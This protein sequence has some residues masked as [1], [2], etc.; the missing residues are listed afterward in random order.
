MPRRPRCRYISGFPD[1]W[2]FS[3]DDTEKNNGVITLTLDEYEVIRLIDKEGYN[4]EQ[5][6]AQMGVAR[7]TVT[8]IYESARHKIAEVIVDGKYLQIAGGHYALPDSDFIK[9]KEKGTKTMRVA[10][11]YENGEIFQHFGHTSQ[12]KVFDVEN[13]QISEG[14]VIDTNGAGHGALAGFL[15]QCRADVLICGGIG[16]GAQMALREAGV[17]LCAGVSGNADEAVKAYVSGSLAFSTSANC[18]HHGHGEGHSCGHHS[19][20]NA[21]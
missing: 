4:Q 20:G 14:Q 1:Y 19:C 10:V 12:F 16:M 18:D 11:T 17:E 5:C 9:M 7:T 15:K 13:G 6:A 21:H 3:P 8:N 2:C